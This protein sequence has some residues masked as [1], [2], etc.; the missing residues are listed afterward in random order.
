M[1]LVVATGNPGKLRE[2][3]EILGHL[4]EGGK[5]ELVSLADLK[6]EAPEEHGATFQENA[7]LK[8]RD[9][10]VK[11]GLWALGDDSGLCVDALNGGPGIRSARYADTDVARRAKLLQA[12]GGLPQA[13]RGAYFFCAV[14]LCAPDGQRLF[15]AEG[16]VAGHIATA[17]RGTHGFGY[18]PLFIP[19]EAHHATL[20][21][22]AAEE[23]NRL[24]H[25]GRALGRLSL[26]LLRLLHD[27]DLKG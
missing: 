24:S 1:K 4:L 3:R 10:A 25:R 5:H 11:S 18:D 2:F 26:L 22:L 12:L 19:D 17:A 13:R 27:G 16:K 23:K 15:R 6:L 7:A 20:A 14:A 21:E 8:A 9:A